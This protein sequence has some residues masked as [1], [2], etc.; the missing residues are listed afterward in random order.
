[1][2]RHLSLLD[3]L[4]VASPCRAS[5]TEMS[6]D[7]RVRFCG[8]CE[9]RVYDFTAMTREEA[10]RLVL[11]H[12]GLLCAR[13]YQRAD[14]TVLTADCPEGVRRRSRKRRLVVAALGAVSTLTAV[15]AMTAFSRAPLGAA[16]PGPSASIEEANR[17]RP[18]PLD[19][20][21]FLHVQGEIS[22]ET[23]AEAL[24]AAAA[25]RMGVAYTPTEEPEV[26]AAPKPRVR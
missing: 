19:V 21:D 24:T 13:F 17:S 1:M 3:D 26:F 12:E 22:S 8:R 9:K 2:R 7:D 14:G 25:R 23:I 20:E 18:E 11:A 6:G 5:W 10:E 4:R 15:T 16:R